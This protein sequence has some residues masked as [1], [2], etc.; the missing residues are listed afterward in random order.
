MT[1][2]RRTLVVNDEE[3]AL[4]RTPHDGIVL[5]RAAASD[6]LELEEGPFEQYERTLEITPLGDGDHEVTE[7]TSWKLAVPIFWVIFWIPFW[8]HVR[9]GQRKASPWWAPAGRLDTRAARVIGLLGVLA[10]VNGYVGTVI[11]QTLTFAADEFC[12]EFE[13]DADGLRTCIDAAH[14]KSARANV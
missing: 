6:R 10:V 11:G 9:A 8:L 3:L 13:V 4:L 1:T 14:D 5:E 7:T 12:A 2:Q